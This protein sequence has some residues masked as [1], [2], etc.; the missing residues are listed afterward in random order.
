M[1]HVKK[2]S[3]YGKK[4]V[5]RQSPL[6]HPVKI[7][8][9]KTWKDY[10]Q[11][12]ANELAHFF[13]HYKNYPLCQRISLFIIPAVIL[14]LEIIFRI[15]SSGRA[16]SVINVFCTVFIALSTGLILSLLCSITKNKTLNGWIAFGIIFLL[17]A[18][19]AF[20]HCLE[21]EFNVYIDYDSVTAGAGGIATEAQAN[22]I[23]VIIGN[24]YK[25][26]IYL[27]PAF[28]YLLFFLVF[29][30]VYFARRRATGYVQPSI[31]AA[32]VIYIMVLMLASN[33]TYAEKLTSQ[34]DFDEAT[35]SFSL[36]LSTD[37]DAVYTVFGNSAQAEFDLTGYTE[38][39]LDEDT[40]YN[41][42]S[43]DLDELM[44]GITNGNITS[45]TEYIKTLLPSEKNE[46][47][48]LFEGMN[49]IQITAESFTKYAIDEELTPVLYMMSTSGIIFE[50]YY[51]PLWSGS[52][53]T[54]EYQLLTGLLPPYGAKSMLKTADNNMYLT[55]GNSLLRTGYSSIAFHNGS[56][57]Y[58]SRNET[59]PN[60]GYTSFF[61]NGN[62]MTGLSN[63]ESSWPQSDVEMMEWIVPNYIEDAEEPFNYY[64]MTLSGHSKYDSTNWI[65]NK[66]M[67]AV[68][69]WAEENG[70]DYT[71][72]TMCYFANNLELEY[73]MEYLL[74]AL[75]E[76]GLLGN[77]VIVISG[78]HYPYS[79]SDD[80]G[81]ENGT[82]TY[83]DV[84][85]NLESLY[86]FM[87]ETDPEY[88]VNSL[89]IWTPSLE[90][91]EQIIVSDPV[92]SIDVLPT[93]LNLFGCEF[94]SRLLAGRD[95]LADD[96]QPLVI[97]SNYSWLTER[98]YYDASDG[99]FTPADGYDQDDEY[100]EEIKQLVQNKRALSQT[101][102][103]N[104]Y[105]DLIYGND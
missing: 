91:S 53:S 21:S 35:R 16:F 25:I 76:E 61:A 19:F 29:K 14:Y 74:E 22:T 39:V 89:I 42:T 100:V 34:Y 13:K 63:T 6:K 67:D 43:I 103:D 49:L 81:Y 2:A 65:A 9:K 37:L 90:D 99:S 66:N 27:L 17:C 64:I 15:M 11:T 95:V 23:A 24:W 97:F 77:T 79:L 33:T 46:Y 8:P 54:G 52:T 36:L 69:E 83:Y 92:S 78:D 70:Y 51:Q 50:D 12:A 18:F 80:Y 7:P 4:G 102:L 30:K 26:L 57:T 10:L 85:E 94:D 98:G 48:G 72:S 68:E 5:K 32:L 38:A 31:C 56:Y 3:R 20:E 96:T 84:E 87:P 101:I 82:L 40:E 59:H 93:L 104:D 88:N 71:F 45:L 28:I 105:Y 1:T 44:E 86:G 62:G 41:V 60:L 47:T 58:F 55:I 73:A 75:E